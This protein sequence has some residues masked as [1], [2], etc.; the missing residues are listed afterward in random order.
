M[1]QRFAGVAYV[2]VNG[3]PIPLRGNL[4]IS[5]SKFER[6]MIAGQDGVH[7][8]QELPRVPYIELDMSALPG[9]NLEDVLNQIDVNVI[10][11]LANGKIY[12][13]VNATC[14][15]GLEEN[16]RDGQVRVRWEGLACQEI[17]VG[18]SAEPGA[19]IGVIGV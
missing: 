6:T 19:G 18:N 3:N 9:V 10:A 15:G 1:A 4:T 12:A 5:P 7:G 8:Y 14:K 11:S 17:N 2:T 13:L 16:A